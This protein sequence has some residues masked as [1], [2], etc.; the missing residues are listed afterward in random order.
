MKLLRHE[1]QWRG[2]ETVVALGMFDGVHLGHAQLVTRAN[3]LAALHDMQSVVLT[4]DAHPLAV[5]AP[6]RAPRALSTRAEKT[7]LISRLRADALIM[8]PFD[9]AY[10]SLSPEDFVREM[11]HA[12]HPRHIVVGFNYTFGYRGSGTPQTLR[13]LGAQYGFETHVV[14]AVRICDEPVS[15]TR[16]RDALF[17]GEIALCTRLLGR[18]YAISGVI[19]HGKHLGHQLGFPTANLRWPAHKALPPRGVYAAY[20]HIEGEVYG[21]ALNIG[22]HPTAPEGEATLEAHLLGT[23]GDFY[24]KHMRLELIEFLRG[25]QKFESLDALRAQI[26]CDVQNTKAHLDMQK[27]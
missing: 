22:R 19:A 23:K 3:H 21:A 10:A 13:T 14:E 9:A 16:V 2:G 7:A 17:A 11:V 6:A 20:A 4:Y 18:P 25:E 5:L 27:Q 26:A 12:L 24:G 8:R 1:E 15:S